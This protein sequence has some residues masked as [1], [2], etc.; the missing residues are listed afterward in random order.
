[1]SQTNEETIGID[2]DKQN[3]IKLF[4]DNVRGVTIQLCDDSNTK[5]CG[6][7]GHWLETMMNVKH[8]AKNEPDINGYEMK[9]GKSATTFIDKSP[10]FMFLDGVSI[11][12]RNKTMKRQ[13]WENYASKKQSEEPTIG[14]WS[15]NKW[16]AS[17]Q[18]MRINEDN[19]VSIVYDCDHD[20]RTNKQELNINAIPHEIMKW[21][22]NSLKMAIEN[23]FNKKGFFKCVKGDK[24]K[25]AF[26]K[27]GFGAPFTFNKWMDCLRTG[28]IYHDSYSKL[29]GR[30]RHS[31]RALNNFWDQLITEEY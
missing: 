12:K 16:N 21:E 5:H 14:G 2:L 23:K 18:R 17:G 15:V 24:E 28:V 4:N 6:K 27:I 8:N 19:S 22:T 3:I 10:D 29:N 20:T 13:F 1:M 9:T 31:F 7:D 25:N 26:S 11:P 30:G